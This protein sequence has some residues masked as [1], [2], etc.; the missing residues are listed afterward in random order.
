MI[1]SSSATVYMA[2]LDV[3]SA[4]RILPIAPTDRP[5]LGFRWRGLFYMDA[6][7]PMGCSSSCAIFEAFS[8]AL[9]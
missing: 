8:D 7:L 1:K 2:K 4:F 5:L 9:H 6:V 3:E